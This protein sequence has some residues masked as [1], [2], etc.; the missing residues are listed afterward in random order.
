LTR[1]EK[2]DFPSLIHFILSTYAFLRLA[3][4]SIYIIPKLSKNKI[5]I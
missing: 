1:R 4:E 3:R 5:F 2:D